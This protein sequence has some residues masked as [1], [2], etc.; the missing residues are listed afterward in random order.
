MN[1]NPMALDDGYEPDENEGLCCLCDEFAREVC[2]NCNEPAC[3]D[4]M[5]DGF[6]LYCDYNYVAV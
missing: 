1:L 2:E 3:G 6:C 5:L 4:H